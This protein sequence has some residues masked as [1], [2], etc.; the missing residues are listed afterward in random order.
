MGIVVIESGQIHI[1]GRTQFSCV[2][3][4]VTKSPDPKV[5]TSTVSAF[6]FALHHSSS[7]ISC[8]GRAV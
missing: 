6:F 4:H 2:P 7:D 1:L 8:G 3:P 5:R